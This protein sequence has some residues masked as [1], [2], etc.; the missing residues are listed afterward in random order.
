MK[1]HEWTA[2]A[3]IVVSSFSSNAAYATDCIGPVYAVSVKYD[4]YVYADWGWGDV[5]FCNLTNNAN[6]PA[7]NSVTVTPATCQGIY[8]ALL[9]AKLSG[10]QMRAAISESSCAGFSG[11]GAA[12]TKTVSFFQIPY[13]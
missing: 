7:P 6:L 4:G 3:A 13:N 1:K 8:S 10:R 5:L 2:L 9:S 12:P 11:S